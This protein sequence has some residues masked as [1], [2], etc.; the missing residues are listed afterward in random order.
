MYIVV[1]TPPWRI[2]FDDGNGAT[3]NA[4][5]LLYFETLSDVPMNIGPPHE[6]SAVIY[7]A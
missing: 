7:S 1:F 5:F 2:S 6:G 3:Y 4:M